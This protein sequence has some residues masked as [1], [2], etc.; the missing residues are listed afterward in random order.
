LGAVAD[1][2]NFQMGILGTGLFV[3][4]TCMLFGQ[5]RDI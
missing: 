5:L 1:C 3:M 4:A 2:W